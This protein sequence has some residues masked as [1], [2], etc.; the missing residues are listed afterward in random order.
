MGRQENR[1]AHLQNCELLRILTMLALI[2]M[3]Q[4]FGA[5]CKLSAIAI[6]V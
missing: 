2:T 5:N 3:P 4:D 1:E 6:E